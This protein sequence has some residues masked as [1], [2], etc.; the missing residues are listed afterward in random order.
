LIAS[1]ARA[2][3]LSLEALGIRDRHVELSGDGACH[4][5]PTDGNHADEPRNASCRDGYGRHRGA[6]IDGRHDIFWTLRHLG[7]SQERQCVEIDHLGVEPRLLGDINVGAHRALGRRHEQP[8]DHSAGWA[9]ELGAGKEVQDGFVDGHRQHFL[10]LKRKG[11]A[12][13]VHRH[14]GDIYLTDRGG[15]RADAHDNVAA[16]ELHI[17]P[18]LL[19]CPAHRGT[20]H[21]HGILDCAWRKRYLRVANERRASGA[22]VLLDLS[23]THHRR[24]NVESNDARLCHCPSLSLSAIKYTVDTDDNCSIGMSRPNLK[25]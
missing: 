3:N 13:L 15:A 6:D 16:R 17:T 12:K 11:K 4:I 14:E 18:Q 21:D 24:A 19:D 20:R 1:T 25:P 10:D 2:T 22:S 8:T 9:I 5:T 23:C 7:R